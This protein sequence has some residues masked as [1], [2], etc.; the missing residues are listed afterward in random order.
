MLDSAASRNYLLGR[1]PHA[2]R[3]R[4]IFSMGAALGDL[5]IDPILTRYARNLRACC[6]QHY[7][8]RSLGGRSREQAPQRVPT[9]PTPCG[10]AEI[11]QRMRHAGCDGIGHNS[12]HGEAP[13]EFFRV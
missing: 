10:A 3:K 13:C 1:L 4:F 7:R 5:A 12:A 2:P 6:E 11:E 8:S 9:L